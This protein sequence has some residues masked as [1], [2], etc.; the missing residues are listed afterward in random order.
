M[1]TFDRQTEK[2]IDTFLVASARWHSMQ[3]GKI[4]TD[5]FFLNVLYVNV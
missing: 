1:H 5:V 2:R 3:L 4:E